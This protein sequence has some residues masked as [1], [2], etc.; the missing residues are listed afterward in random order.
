MRQK[1]YNVLKYIV[2]DYNVNVD[3]MCRVRTSVCSGLLYKK[4][5]HS[6]NFCLFLL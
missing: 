5:N 4:M 3:T 2:V 1:L 6:Y